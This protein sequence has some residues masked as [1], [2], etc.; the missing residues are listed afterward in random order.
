LSAATSLVVCVSLLGPPSLSQA[1]PPSDAVSEAPEPSRDR[2]DDEADDAADDDAPAQSEEADDK[3]TDDEEAEE[4][5]EEADA[6]AEDP[7]SDE[8]VRE[9]V[10]AD[11]PDPPSGASAT[12]RGKHWFTQGQSFARDKRFVTA[13][14][15]FGRSAAAFEE[16]EQA[17]SRAA[18]LYNEGRSWELADRPVDA[19]EAYDR[20]VALG[21]PS[22]AEISTAKIA[23]SRLRERVGTIKRVRLPQGREPHTIQIDDH[24]VETDDF[25]V[26]VVPGPVEVRAT[27]R[28]GREL[29]AEVVLVAGEARVIELREP[30]AEGPPDFGGMQLPPIE[31]PRYE[32]RRRATRRV[33]YTSVALTGASGVLWAVFGGLAAREDRLYDE[34]ACPEP[35]CPD[36]WTGDPEPHIRRFE[37]YKP[38]SNAM[39]GITGG[40][41]LTSVILAIVTFTKPPKQ[42][43]QTQPG[44]RAQRPTTR[45]RVRP[46][47]LRLEF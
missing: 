18:A 10:V 12:E 5:S 2:A 46:R 41:A 23:I 22:L 47:G 15:A 7:V 27:D 40:F 30:N 21:D 31:D 14:V 43:K 26:Y 6:K 20:F 13:A 16:A 8:P 28:R 25:P 3:E 32:A 11:I 45:V 1:A 34:N 29:E 33:F 38:A 39:A 17:P 24:I 37:I 9:D 35:M 42:T 4:A 36:G 19:L 44:A